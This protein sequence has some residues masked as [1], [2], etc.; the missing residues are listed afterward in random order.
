MI[1]EAPG[2]QLF[3][4]SFRKQYRINERF[5][6]RF[7]ADLFNALNKANLRGLSTNTSNRDFGSLTASG[8]ARNVQMGLRLEF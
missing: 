7:Q 2:L 1:V 4:V 8:P 5:S 6:L 3:D